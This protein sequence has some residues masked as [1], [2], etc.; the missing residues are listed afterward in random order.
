M[1]SVLNAWF[2]QHIIQSTN[3]IHLLAMQSNTTINHRKCSRSTK[4]MRNA[5]AVVHSG[6]PRTLQTR[7]IELLKQSRLDAVLAGHLQQL[8]R[9]TPGNNHK[10]VCTALTDKYIL[11]Q[12]HG[13]SVTKCA[14]YNLYSWTDWRFIRQRRVLIVYCIRTHYNQP[15]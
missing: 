12:P 1:V 5:A 15:T 2:E 10:I 9:T 3:W 14:L 7:S 6:H 13:L 11:L 4:Q 8:Q